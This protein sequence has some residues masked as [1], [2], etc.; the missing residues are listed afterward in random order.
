VVALWRWHAAEELE[1][2]L[3]RDRI[4]AVVRR[5][6]REYGGL[7]MLEMIEQ[8]PRLDATA[9]QTVG[10]K[11]YDGL[12]IATG[13]TARSL[14]GA[15]DLPRV[16]VLRTLDDARSVRRAL[17]QARRIVVVGAGFIG[18][19]V[20][21]SARGLEEAARK[22]GSSLQAPFMTMSFLALSVIPE[23]KITDLG[24]VDTVRF[25][26]VYGDDL[27]HGQRTPGTTAS[28]TTRAGILARSSA[29]E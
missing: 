13:S 1:H 14:P 11:G 10:V 27:A 20:A 21:A 19:E 6:A 12:V 8:D 17:D 22:L 9:L 24:L 16:Y 29:G 4:P 28:S 15:E 3:K 5:G 26:L 7:N 2:N 18:L 23:L 25:E